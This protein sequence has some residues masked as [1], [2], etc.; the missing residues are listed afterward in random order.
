MKEGE[1]KNG[2]GEE[3]VVLQDYPARAG[4]RVRMLIQGEGCFPQFIFGDID[5]EIDKTLLLTLSEKKQLSE[6]DLQKIDEMIDEFAR[7]AKEKIR[8]QVRKAN[9]KSSEFVPPPKNIQMTP[10]R[11]ER[12]VRM[13]SGFRFTPTFSFREEIMAFIEPKINES[14]NSML[15]EYPNPLNFPLKYDELEQGISS[16]LFAITIEASRNYLLKKLSQIII[17]TTSEDRVKIEQHIAAI[18]SNSFL[19]NPLWWLLRESIKE[20]TDKQA[21]DLRYGLLQIR[22]IKPIICDSIEE[23]NRADKELKVPSKVTNVIEGLFYREIISKGTSF[24]TYLENIY[25][26]LDFEFLQN[27]VD[28]ETFVLGIT[29]ILAKQFDIINCQ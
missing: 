18:D 14:L 6:S 7:R 9:F 27:L 28:K 17:I 29:G 23:I 4:Y 13:R 21:M 26:Q 2:E 25:S 12:M 16:E 5:Y 1:E 19:T 20:L 22:G 11:E 10:S 3:L 24:D 15:S 8:R